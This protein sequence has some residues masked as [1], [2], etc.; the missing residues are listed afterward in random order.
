MSSSDGFDRGL[1]ARSTGSFGTFNGLAWY[2][3]TSV[4]A[5]SEPSAYNVF[6]FVEHPVVKA[7]DGPGS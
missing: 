1:D 7:G 6:V 4:P 5:S 2:C 3:C